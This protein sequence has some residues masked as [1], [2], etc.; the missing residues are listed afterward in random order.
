[1]ANNNSVTFYLGTECDKS[2]DWYFQIINI[3]SEYAVAV[4]FSGGTIQNN[5]T[6]YTFQVEDNSQ[7]FE[8]LQRGKLFTN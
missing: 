6:E 2:T 5:V 3:S 1:M 4:A 8:G 7:D